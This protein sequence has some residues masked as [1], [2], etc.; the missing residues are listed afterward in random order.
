MR[1]LTSYINDKG[2]KFGIC[3]LRI[4]VRKFLTGFIALTSCASLDGAAGETTCAGRAGSLYHE[5][6]DAQTYIDWGVDYLK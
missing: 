3:T 1:S 5:D 2:L 4:R 6:T